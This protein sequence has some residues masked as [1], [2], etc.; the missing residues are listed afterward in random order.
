KAIKL[1]VK[2]FKANAHPSGGFGY[3]SPGTGGLTSVGCLCMQLL[4]ASNEGEVKRALDVMDTWT[5]TFSSYG[6]INAEIKNVKKEEIK[7]GSS[8]LAVAKSKL[9]AKIPEEERKFF[10]S[11]AQYY[12][13]YATQCKFHEGGKHWDNWNKAMKPRYV[14]A[15]L[16]QEKAIKDDKGVDRDIGWW[17]N[18]DTHTDRPV[19]DTCLAALQLMVYYRYL[20]TTSKEAVQVEEEIVA[21]STDSDDITVDAGNL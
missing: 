6:L 17:E 8:A 3:T 7:E 20:P 11:S 15:Q 19:M 4:G 10:S 9:A 1:A 5:P 13:Y 21:T 16:I 12:F 18:A 14:K 2:G